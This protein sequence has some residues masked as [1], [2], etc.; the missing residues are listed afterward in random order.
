MQDVA[1]KSQ[2]VVIRFMVGCLAEPSF[3]WIVMTIVWRRRRPVAR[4]LR[5]GA[6]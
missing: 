2:E 4:A 3:D 6:L 5:P 1:A